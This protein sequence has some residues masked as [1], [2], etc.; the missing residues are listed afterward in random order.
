MGSQ[1]LE[2][3]THTHPSP[4]ILEALGERQAGAAACRGTLPGFGGLK[5]D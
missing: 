5:G 2:G 1:A 4:E 3:S